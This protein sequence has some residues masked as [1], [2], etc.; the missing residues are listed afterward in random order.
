MAMLEIISPV[1]IMGVINLSKN[2]FYKGS[3]ATG[4]EEI[5]RL[6]RQM[7]KDGADFIDLGGAVNRSISQV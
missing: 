7:E 2:S 1:R 5:R 6:T 4:K 3:V